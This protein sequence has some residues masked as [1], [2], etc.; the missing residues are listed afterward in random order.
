MCVIVFPLRS[1]I[2]EVWIK[3][4]K[5][6][7][8]GTSS[9]EPIRAINSRIG[10]GLKSD[11]VWWLTHRKAHLVQS[12]TPPITIM[13]LKHATLQPLFNKP[14]VAQ[15]GSNIFNLGG[16]LCAKAGVPFFV[17]NPLESVRKHKI[18]VTAI[19]KSFQ[20]LLRVHI[21]FFPT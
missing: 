19:V 8:A 13:K 15:R 16:V 6:N 5:G 18:V 14:F 4:K 2:P 7:N 3:R 1:T 10:L 9:D 17:V 11:L 12:K 21:G 20:E